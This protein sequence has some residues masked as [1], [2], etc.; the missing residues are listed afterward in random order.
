MVWHFP[1]SAALE[2]SS[3]VG[4]YKLVRN[5]YHLHDPSAEPL[6]L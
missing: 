4:D 5:Y 1:N 6:E 2:S 3:R